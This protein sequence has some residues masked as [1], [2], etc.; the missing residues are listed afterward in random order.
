[1][2]PLQLSPSSLGGTLALQ[3]R[4][5][6][7][8]GERSDTVDALV[9]A[10]ARSVRV[11]LHQQGQVMLRL[12]W[13]GESLQ[14]TRAPQ[15]PPALSAQR[16]LDDLQLVHWPAASIRAALPP[17]WE[18]QERATQRRL[19]HRDHVVVTV[20]GLGRREAWL[21]NHRA[22]YRLEISSVPVRP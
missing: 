8:H 4:L 3:Q 10:D 7:R 11:V 14:Q 1:M 2:P 20:D 13:D 22:G 17:G 16:V 15:L 21:E 6:F 9:E 12:S 5:V 18:L 19:L